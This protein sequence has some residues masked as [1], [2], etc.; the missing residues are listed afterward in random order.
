MITVFKIVR[1][2]PLGSKHKR[3]RIKAT[4]FFSPLANNVGGL[5]IF[6]QTDENGCT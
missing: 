5:L 3:A 2:G 6:A 4:A 1:F